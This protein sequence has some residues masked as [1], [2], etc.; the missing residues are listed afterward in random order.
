MKNGFV[1]TSY[2]PYLNIHQGD[3]HEKIARRA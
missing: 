2:Y 1:P 3:G